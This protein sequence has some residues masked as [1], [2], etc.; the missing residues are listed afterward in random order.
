MAASTLRP[1]AEGQVH[2]PRAAHLTRVA[3]SDFWRDADACDAACA[4]RFERVVARYRAYA[5]RNPQH[6]MFTTIEGLTSPPAAG[7]RHLAAARSASCRA[8][9]ARRAGLVDATDCP[10]PTALSLA[11]RRAHDVVTID[12]DLPPPPARLERGDAR[13]AR[14]RRIAQRDGRVRDARVRVRDVGAAHAGVS[15]GKGEGEVGKGT[16]IGGGAPS[17]EEGEESGTAARVV[18]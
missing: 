8:P 7:A 12:G 10:R 2:L 4:R 17:G 16:T 18:A 15:T 5:W 6:A 9:A 14:A 13:T 1:V 3:A 11:R